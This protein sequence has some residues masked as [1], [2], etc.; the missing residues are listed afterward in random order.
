MASFTLNNFAGTHQIC[1]LEN[2]AM[3]GAAGTRTIEVAF[4]GV[5]PD[6]VAVSAQLTQVAATNLKVTCYSGTKQDG[7][8]ASQIQSRAISSG[9]STVSDMVDTGPADTL[10]LEFSVVGKRYF[11]AVFS[12]DNAGASDILDGQVS[13]A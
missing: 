7:S 9:A 4:A 12:A 2:I 5:R 8:D 1:E 6:T 13:F 10:N 11:K 3:N